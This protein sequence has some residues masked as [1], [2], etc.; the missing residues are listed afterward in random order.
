MEQAFSCGVKDKRQNCISGNSALDL[1]Q[2]EYQK[3]MM[4]KRLL[5]IGGS[6]NVNSALTIGSP[7]VFHCCL[8][9]SCM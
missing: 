5:S 3:Q 8:T 6:L 4:A 9:E 1:S 2:I 7:P